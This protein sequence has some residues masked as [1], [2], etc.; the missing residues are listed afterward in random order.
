T[1]DST[2]FDQIAGKFLHGKFMGGQLHCIVLN[3]NAQNL[4]FNF[5]DD[6]AVGINSSACSWLK[7]DFHDGKITKVKMAKDVQATYSPINNDTEYWLED[8]SPN[9]ELRPSKASLRP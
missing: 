9:F 4:F 6:Q 1:E 2:R 8:C 7:L 3:G 5:D